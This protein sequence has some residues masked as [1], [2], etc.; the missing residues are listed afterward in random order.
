MFIS[1]K[2]S[3]RFAFLLAAVFFVLCLTT[4]LQHEMWRDE[5]HSWLIARDSSSISRLLVNK[6][7]E[8]HPDLWYLCLYA[9]SRVFREPIAMQVFH[10]LIATTSIYLLARFAPFSRLQKVLLSFGYYFLFEYASISRNY[11]LGILFLIIFSILFKDR[12]QKHFLLAGL[13]FLLMQTSFYGLLIALPLGMILVGEHLFP[14]RGRRRDWAGL[15][16]DLLILTLGAYLS[17]QRIQPPPD[18]GIYLGWRTSLQVRYL[19]RVLTLI[20]K[21]YFPLPRPIYHFWDTNFLDWYRGWQV[22]LSLSLLIFFS[23]FF[24]KKPVVLFFYLFATLS[25]LIFSYVKIFGS[26]RH[27][28]HLFIIL[29]FSLWLDH[30]YPPWK[31]PGRVSSLL[32]RASRRCF[33]ALFLLILI[34]NIIGGGQAV[35]MDW[36]HPFT[37]S[38]DVAEYIIDN[39]LNRGAIAGDVDDAMLAFPIYLDRKIYYPRSDTL[40]TFVCYDG[41][42]RDRKMKTWGILTRIKEFMARQQQNV[43]IILNYR[44]KRKHLRR[45]NK[46]QISLSPGPRPV[47]GEVKQLR[48]FTRSLVPDEHYFLYTMTSKK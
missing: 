28:G 35:I 44:I 33:P 36:L 6:M 41:G 31:R 38:R 19:Q 3:A 12:R 46:T 17:I 24:I 43:L 27:Y 47:N 32:T 48:E 23:I 20:W 34:T 13:L 7:Y 29:I 16:G 9:I 30:Y 21:A 37:R 4:M 2:T 15:A 18:S 26:I 42:K 1:N 39:R 22:A 14:G 25:L 40:G 45:W 5:L 8:G 11:A 10:L